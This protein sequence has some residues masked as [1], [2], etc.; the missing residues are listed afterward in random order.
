MF[1]GGAIA[2]ILV[3]LG[4]VCYNGVFMLRDPEQTVS[5][6]LKLITIMLL[7]MVVAFYFLTRWTKLNTKYREQIPEDTPYSDKSHRKPEESSHSTLD[8]DVTLGECLRSTDFWAPFCAV[9]G[10]A[11]FM[12]SM[13]FTVAVGFGAVAL[14]CFVLGLILAVVAAITYWFGVRC[15]VATEANN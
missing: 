9:F 13:V 11:F 3:G 10:G 6:L 7:T 5:I 1:L 12:N 8:S 15:R 14:V 2:V 4:I